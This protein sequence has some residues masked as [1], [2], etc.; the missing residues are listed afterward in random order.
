MFKTLRIA[1]VLLFLA[2]SAS[3]C[4]DTAPDDDM[5]EQQH[6]LDVLAPAS[7]DSTCLLSTSTCTTA[8][9]DAMGLETTCADYEGS[10]DLLLAKKGR[11][12]QTGV[13]IHEPLNT[14]KK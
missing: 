2:A 3:A 6:D 12:P 4:L 7:C 11:N 13:V 9:A 14:G 10:C 5:T 1:C 8:C